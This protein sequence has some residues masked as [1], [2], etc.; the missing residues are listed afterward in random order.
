M[1]RL[2]VEAID[3][4]TSGLGIVARMHKGSKGA[5]QRRKVNGEEW[6]PASATYTGSAEWRSSRCAPR[7]QVGI[8]RLQE[9][10]C[11]D[12]VGVCQGDRNRSIADLPANQD[13]IRAHQ[14]DQTR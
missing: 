4:V 2:E 7:G 6:L 12:I 9:V 3:T 10:Q 14:V 8:F 1:V 5:F 13:A 11:R